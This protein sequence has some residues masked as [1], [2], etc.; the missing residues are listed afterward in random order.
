MSLL[1]LL[2][3]LL[4][5][6]AGKSFLFNLIDTPGGT[7]GWLDLVLNSEEEAVL[8]FWKFSS[9]FYTGWKVAVSLLLLLPSSWGKSLL[10]N[11]ID[12]PSAPCTLC[13][14]SPVLWG[15]VSA[16]GERQAILQL[17]QRLAILARGV[18]GRW[19]EV[20]CPSDLLT[21][22]GAGLAMG[23]FRSCFQ[24]S[25][26]SLADGV[27]SLLPQGWGYLA[28]TVSHMPPHHGAPGLGS[29]KAAHAG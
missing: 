5:S 28:V 18:V 1:L 23:C 8:S 12:T 27:Q 16:S 4:P 20:P 9:P 21:S 22:A 26:S 10:V 3:L 2:L 11:L 15:G 13:M 25:A 19:P 17:R 14:W 24:D 29:G 7:L 6:S